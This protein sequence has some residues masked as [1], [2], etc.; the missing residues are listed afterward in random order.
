MNKLII[1]KNQCQ[2]PFSRNTF[3]ALIHF[4]FIKNGISSVG[5]VDLTTIYE[6]ACVLELYEFEFILECLT[7][8]NY[9]FE[10][11]LAPNQITISN[12]CKYGLDAY[13]NITVG[14]SKSRRNIANL[15]S[16]VLINSNNLHE[17]I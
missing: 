14:F 9:V 17:H 11:N 2:A 13:L 12:L 3:D 10:N 1:L 16:Q 6:D 4:H 5:P 15:F 8:N 7:M